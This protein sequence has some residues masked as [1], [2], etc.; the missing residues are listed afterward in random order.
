M[1]YRRAIRFLLPSFLLALCSLNAAAGTLNYFS[2][3][4]FDTYD[5][6]RQTNNTSLSYSLT[7]NG[8]TNTA[9]ANLATGKLGVLNAGSDTTGFAFGQVIAQMGDTITVSGPTGGLQLGVNFAENGTSTYT[10]PSGAF[11][12][13]WVFAYKP[14]TFDQTFYNTPSNILYAA[15]YLLG[16][17]TNTANAAA[18]FAA[19]N[20]PLVGTYGDGVNS[21]PLNIPFA[22]LGSNFQL[23]LVLSSV[24]LDQTIGDTWSADFSHTVGVTLSAPNGVTLTSASGDLPGT[25]SGVPEPGSMLL[26]GAGVA[27]IALVKRRSA[28]RRRA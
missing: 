27:A 25:T 5:P 12:S 21:I 9:S 6:G 11:T 15:G 4:Y 8:A 22:T 3:V 13:L 24:M 28:A 19:N 1:I 18:L 17:G 16:T 23:N 2:Y 14:G 26:A 7:E 10:D 20:V